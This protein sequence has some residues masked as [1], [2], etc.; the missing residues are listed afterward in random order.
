MD[1]LLNL[2]DLVTSDTLTLAASGI[3][4]LA[5]LALLVLIA[6]PA[7][8]RAGQTSAPVTRGATRT[9]TSPSA[10]AVAA[11]SLVAAGR[12]TADI[13]RETGLSRDA[14]ALLSGLAS[15]NAR[16]K[17]PP[18]ARPSLFARLTG[19]GRTSDQRTQATA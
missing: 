2:V 14:L 6:W 4:A 10:R 17:A 5:L 11:R 9:G 8:D 3:L 7:G 12:T 1:T 19:A 16:Q 15:A 13:A 18:S